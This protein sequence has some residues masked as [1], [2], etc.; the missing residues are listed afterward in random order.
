MERKA[1]KE[2]LHI[3]GWLDRV[4]EVVGRGKDAYLAGQAWYSTKRSAGPS[5][6]VAR[7]SSAQSRW[8]SLPSARGPRT[9][10]TSELPDRMP[11]PG[12]AV[13]RPAAEVAAPGGREP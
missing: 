6:L 1:A 2:L 8:S 4:D 12:R 7:P 5:L 10:P 11:G 3:R 13:G 9:S